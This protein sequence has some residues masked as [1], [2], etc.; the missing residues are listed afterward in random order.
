MA[1]IYDDSQTYTGEIVNFTSTDKAK[2]TSVSVPLTYSQDL[3]GYSHPW[4][5]GGGKNLYFPTGRTIEYGGGAISVNDDGKVSYTGTPTSAGG[6]NT[7]VLDSFTLQEGTYTVS[8]SGTKTV[9]LYLV[10]EGDNT[11]LITD[12]NGGT[13]TLSETTSLHFGINIQSAYIGTTYN[14]SY[15]IQVEEG[16]TATSFAPYSNICP[17]SGLTGLSLTR[18]GKNF[19][20]PHLYSGMSYDPTV[21]TTIAFTDNAQQLTD[22]GD[23]TFSVTSAA[24]WTYYIMLA[25]IDDVSNWWAKCKFTST[26]SIRTSRG[27]LD[28]NFKVLSVFNNTTASQSFDNAISIVEGAAYYYYL[29]T[30]AGTKYATLTVTEPQIEISSSAA[31][32]YEPYN[33]NTYAV[34]W[35]TQ[36]GTVYHG[37]ID[38]IAGQLTGDKASVDL[39]SIN[40]TY[41]SGYEYPYFI[42]TM[43]N[44]CV[45]GSTVQGQISVLCSIYESI[46]NIAAALFRTENHNYQCCLNSA[47]STRRLLVQNSA[48]T[49]AASFKAAMSGVQLVYDLE[50]PVTYRLTPRQISVL[51]ENYVRASNGASITVVVSDVLHNFQGWLLKVG[52]GMTLVPTEMIKAETYKV[53]PNQRMEETAERDSTGVLWRE[54]VP[55]MPPK[56]EF[57]TPAAYDTDIN[58]LNAIFRAAYSNEQERKLRVAF[59]DPEENVYQTWECYMPNID[60]PI[61]TID[62]DAKTILYDEIRYAFIGY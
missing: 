41:E 11:N 37:T 7:L 33:G 6:R 27:C 24:T 51:T 46:P 29:F 36:A 55:N 12:V 60:F 32:A 59:Y 56:I 16:S 34:D 42:G 28:E 9:P 40:W 54:T 18:H 49:D 53:S 35:S 38:P 43:P 61:R 45:V 62:T 47:V 57:N 13:F 39:G 19:L 20:S 23:R 48:Y 50:T 2:I 25:R 14:D 1:Y 5:A 21:G 4:P 52:S 26:G 22:N 30:N 31:T 58:A 3:H 8:F 17:I 44:N 15:Y 10:N